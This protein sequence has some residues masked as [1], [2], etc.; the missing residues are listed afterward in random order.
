MQM[1]GE[2][3]KVERPAVARQLSVPRGR[4]RVGHAR[5]RR[6][7]RLA[8]LGALLA[9]A[10]TLAA[11]TSSATSSST[12]TTKGS[13]ST[14][15]S[16]TSA[17]TSAVVKTTNDPTLGTI[18]VDANGRTLYRFQLDHQGMSSCTGSCASLWPPLTVPSGSQPAAGTGVSSLG[19]IQ[20]SDGTHQVTYQG[21]PLYLYKGDTAAGQTHGNGVGGVWSVVKVTSGSSAGSGGGAA[22]GSGMTGSTGSTSSGSGY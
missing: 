18:L 22:G 7:A 4:D 6:A 5:R 8:P 20:R 11:C 10:V 12:S 13:T 16:G 21:Y 17:S 2:D 1:R 9:G 3:V 15:A 19:V 14:A